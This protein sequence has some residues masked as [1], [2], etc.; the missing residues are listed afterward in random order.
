MNGFLKIK[1]LA[2]I[3]AKIGSFVKKYM[4][5]PTTK[6]SFIKWKQLIYRQYK[7]NNKTLESKL[8]FQQ[9]KCDLSLLAKNLSKFAYFQKQ[10][11]F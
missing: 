4:P 8:L 7:T 10:K 11:S 1:K 6:K 9:V 2:K 3:K 5:E